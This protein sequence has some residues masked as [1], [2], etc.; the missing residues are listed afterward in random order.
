M[1]I[2]IFD[3]KCL[4]QLF[5]W[6][7]CFGLTACGSGPT[8]RPA[9]LPGSAVPIEGLTDDE[10]IAFYKCEQKFKHDFNVNEGLG[11]LFNEQS[12]FACHG[13]PG[14]AGG[15]GTDLKKTLCTRIARRKPLSLAAKLP[16]NKAL[17]DVYGVDIDEL[18]PLGGP[19][20]PR[21]T[22]T[23]E[24]PSMFPAN[25]SIF[26]P[27]LPPEAEFIS[28]RQAGQLFGSGLLQAIP[29]ATL[30]D[31]RKKQFAE[32]PKVCGRLGASKKIFVDEQYTYGKFGWKGQH[33][34]LL[35][36]SIEAMQFE[37]G[38]TTPPEPLMKMPS[39]RGNTIPAL[40]AHLP[41]N[42]ENDGS[43]AAQ[44][45]FFM[46][47][48]APPNRGEISS[49]VTKGEAVFD[50][51]ECAVCHIPELKTGAKV[52]IP[53]AD[54]TLPDVAALEAKYGKQWYTSKEAQLKV[55]E[56]KALENQPV[57]AY[58]DLLNHKL[59]LKLADGIPQASAGGDYWRT[60]PLWGLRNRTFLLHDGRT[61]DIGEAIEAHGGQA[62]EAIVRYKSLS[63]A[64]KDD[65]LTFLR[66]L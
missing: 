31:V 9:S 51:C 1:Q 11:P 64:E 32:H 29:D 7:L 12:C 43:L 28:R 6:L 40:S 16:R 37:M 59:G 26:A 56:V 15:P 5:V 20:L 33:N 45:S 65:L 63:K 25:A 50:K 22:V 61:T 24:F 49:A 52:F 19:V 39:G 55:V 47:L 30:A 23:S 41:A 44:F 62:E 17:T 46:A 53:A 13:S 2:T 10:L 48:L 8:G 57:K 42:P 27:P 54:A 35:N 18:T 66:S 4:R 3:R 21:K 34:S 60:T 14:V 36:F 38:L 58:S